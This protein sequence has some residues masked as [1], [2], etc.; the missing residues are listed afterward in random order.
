MEKKPGFTIVGKG[1]PV[2]DAREK[3]TGNLKYAV[4]FELQGMVYGKILR[5]PHPHANITRIDT[6]NA[7]ALPG[8]VGIVTHED[9]PEQ[10]WH[11]VWLNYQGRILDSRARFVGDE[12]AAVAASSEKIALE[13]LDLI[14]VEYELLPAVF[15]SEDAMKEG[16]PQVQEEG[17]AREPNVYEWGDIKQGEKE[18]D[19]VVEVDI[20]FGSQHYAPVG[21]NATIAEWKG[22]RVTVWTA[23]QTPS[24]LQDGIAGGFGIPRSKVR[25][26]GLPSGSSMGMWWSNNFMLVAALL[27]KKARKPVKI[28]LDY[29]ECMATVK[30]RHKERTRGRMGCTKDG[31]VTFI[32]VY[33]I[34]DN[35]GYGFKIEVGYFNIDQWGGKSPHGRYECQGVSTNLVTAG[36]MRAVGDVTMG[37]A[38]ERLADMLA[39]KVNMDPVEFRIKNQ[40]KP[41]DPLRQTWARTYLRHNEKEYKELL[42]DELRD[43][44]PKLFYLS[45]G[46]T[47]EILKMGA[48]EIGWKDK[49]I[50]WGKPY[51]VEGPKRRAVG[52]GTGIHISGEEMEGNTSAIVRIYKDGSAKLF[53]SIG[54]HGTGSET[55]QA[56]IASETL[57][58]PI[59]KVEVEAGDTDSSP[60]SRGSIASTTTFR[61]GFATWSAC[62]DAK[63]QLL[64]LAAREFFE[65]DAS[66]L[67]V[68]E[69]CV[70]SESK[71]DLKVPI[72]DVIMQFR[73]EALGP[74]DSITGRSYLPMPPSTAYSRHFAAHFV[75]LEVDTDTGEIKLLDYVAGQDSGTVINPKVLENQIIGGGILGAGF[76]LYE[77]LKFDDTGKILNPNLTDYKLLRFGDFPV[78]PRMLFH[79][80]YEPTGPFGAK[81][82]GEAPSAAAP[83]AVCQAVYNAIGTWVDV[84]MTPERVLKALEK[85]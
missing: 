38:V 33:H 3:V 54:R 49:W 30:R 9:S 47:K 20:K 83:P 41:G 15:D 76:A 23:T 29:D 69:G 77:V 66:D 24:E 53:V 82:A 73:A 21:R 19:Y 14:E 31:K 51:H 45:T 13:A 35:G 64:E 50:G 27:A 74:T 4:D 42:P 36:C 10:D 11:G 80:S 6:T 5:S 58:I 18:S 78:Q 68:T 72:P 37:S 1:I 84:P 7:E 2:K 52:V 48:E 55:T 40:I 85:F 81:S 25:V 65:V 59:N 57:G 79:E 71:P 26:I 34:M 60:W 32:D 46:S 56:Q 8:V 70:I 22:D 61:T 44:W 63:R 16:A 12:I 43:K 28:E 67:D 17:N 62:L 75:D 39:E